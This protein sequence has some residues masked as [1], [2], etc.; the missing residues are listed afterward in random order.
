MTVEVSG[1][2]PRIFKIALI[3]TRSVGKT[4]LLLRFHEKLFSESPLSTVGANFTCHQVDRKGEKI[5]LQIWDTAGQEKYAE[6]SALYCRDAVCC[7]AVTD[8]IA[9]ANALQD[10]D[11]HI[12]RYYRN[13]VLADP[14]VVVAANKADLLT[15]PVKAK[16]DESLRAFCQERNLKYFFTSAK[17]GE[18]V[19]ALFQEVV[20]QVAGA[21]SPNRTS[22]PV[23]ASDGTGSCC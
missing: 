1:D 12:T 17:S 18:N 22:A 3:G 6:I 14:V 9:D 19:S 20:D 11:A 13:C 4:C 23:E 2:E 5:E 7:V 16:A 10:L 15:E 21:T 8:A